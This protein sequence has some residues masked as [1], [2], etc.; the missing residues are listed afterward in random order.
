MRCLRWD[1]E[2]HQVNG[3]GSTFHLTTR[4]GRNWTL[5]AVAFL[6][7]Q[8]PK[9]KTDG[10]DVIQ[11]TERSIGEAMNTKY[12]HTS[13]HRVPIQVV[14]GVSGEVRLNHELQ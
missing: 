3:K 1:P 11:S 7:V 2:G 4:S 12:F 14:S 5:Q 9:R 10:N 8:H 6:I 13:A